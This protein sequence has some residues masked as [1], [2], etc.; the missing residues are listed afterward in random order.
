MKKILSILITLATVSA[1]FATTGSLVYEE[2]GTANTN[3]TAELTYSLT[4][5]PSEDPDVP[6]VNTYRIG[7]SSKKVQL[8]SDEPVDET[9]LILEVGD[10][11][12]GKIKSD[13]YVYWKIA[14]PVSCE[15]YLKPSSMK[16]TDNQ[17][18]LLHINFSTSTDS[19]AGDY[20]TA[21]T[22]ENTGELLSE[23][24]AG[25]SPNST[26]E[27]TAGLEKL[28][29]EYNASENTDDYQF[30]GCQLLKIETNNI[31]GLAPDTYSGKL[32]LTIKATE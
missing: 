14:S 32:M 2:G 24:N 16:G 30:A 7:F 13:I 1:L 29:C 6:V 8:I 9:S 3:A 11:F 15:I 17:S 27:R 4:T 22:E 10:D 12:I 25:E 28:V 19:L 31:A 20:G 5:K 21:Y 23:E 26:A 18:N